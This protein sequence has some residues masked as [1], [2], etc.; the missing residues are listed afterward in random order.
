MS[1]DSAVAAPSC[2][3]SMQPEAE[4]E[5]PSPSVLLGR[6]ARWVAARGGRLYVWGDEFGGGFETMKASTDRPEGVEFVQT[7]AVTEFELT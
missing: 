3:M 7:D 2:P 6:V 1:G 4:T 5:P